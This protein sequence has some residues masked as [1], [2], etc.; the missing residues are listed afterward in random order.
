MHRIIN[1]DI[2]VVGGNPGGCSAA[3]A[4]ARAGFRVVLLEASPTLGG[5]NANG[6]FGFDCGTPQA[7]SGIA[8]EVADRIR[9]HYQTT[10]LNDPLHRKRADLVWES[11]VAAK[12]WHELAGETAGLTI[13]TRAVATSVRLDGSRINEVIWH[14]ANDNMGNVDD[15]GAGN[16]V[17]ARLVIDASYEV[18][19][20]AWAGVPFRLGREARSAEEPHA[21]KIFFSNHE[22]S[23]AHGYLPHSILPGSTG[24]ADDAIM[25]FVCRLH[26]RLYDDPSSDAAHRLR[27]PPPGYEP[28]SYAWGPLGVDA[29]GQP[30]YFNTLYVLVNG[31]YLLN[32]MARGNNLV[33]PNRE[34]ILA[35]PRERKAL[36]QRFVDHSLGYL[37]YIQNEGGLPQLG[38]AHDEFKD[39]GNVPYLI[40]VRE[41]RRTLGLKTLTEADV[42]PWLAGDGW[43]P[44]PKP[45]VVAIGDWTYESQ[46]CAD[47]I[48]AGYPYPD[49]YITGRFTRAPYQVPYGCLIPQKVE[50]LLVCGGISA[51]H[52]AAGA[53]RCEAARIHLGIAAGTAASLALQRELTPAEV[54]IGQLQLR[55]LEQ[56]VKLVYFADVETSHPHFLAIQWAG[57]RGFLPRDDNLCFHP[58]DGTRWGDLVTAIVT[59]L[60]IPV[61]VTSLHFENLSPREPCFRFVETLYDLSSRAGVDLFGLAVLADEDPMQEFLRIFPKM[62]L[63]KFEPNRV[64]TQTEAAKFLGGVSTCLGPEGGS[65]TTLTAAGRTVSLSR[66]QMCEW[67]RHTADQLGPAI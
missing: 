6:T 62:K 45:D 8:E 1:T 35:H 51:T 21:G 54:P 10:G 28:A 5:M 60:G 64:V 24:A 19:V 34:Y 9:A 38:L 18:D 16:V 59:C 30:I 32:R 33:G 17:R 55:L 22:G 27:V 39:N 52:I 53:V 37:Y 12:I 23:P 20:A 63:L 31:K 48:P 44:P 56:R 29:Q 11:H 13:H 61:S 25:A 47:D 14:P 42:N 57:I 7:L 50:N 36:R 40:Y 3:I 49:G 58:D 43:R 46:G 15:S 26:C 65:T 4:A 2:L 67:L 66:G 41:A